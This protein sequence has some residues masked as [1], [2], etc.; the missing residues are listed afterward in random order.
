M[1][2]A[3]LP[4]V[5]TFALAC[6]MATLG[7]CAATQLPDEPKLKDYELPQWVSPMKSGLRLVVQEDHSA[8]LVTVVAI[9]GVGST[10]DPKGVEGLAHFV[11]H[12]AFRSRFLGEAPIMDH[13]KRMG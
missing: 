6:A 1:K 9:Y 12:L 10:S 4:V 3:R 5:P 7:G 11:E 8:P 13:L 2:K